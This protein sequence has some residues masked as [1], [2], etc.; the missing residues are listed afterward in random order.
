MKGSYFRK[1]LWTPGKENAKGKRL[2][3]GDQVVKF[4]AEEKKDQ[5]EGSERIKKEIGWKDIVRR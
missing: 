3:K 2:T 4:W 5:D 1:E